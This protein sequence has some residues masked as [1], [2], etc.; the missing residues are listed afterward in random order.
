MAGD[1]EFTRSE[2]QYQLFELA[3]AGKKPG[4]LTNDDFDKEKSERMAALQ[5]ARENYLAAG[6]YLGVSFVDATLAD[7]YT[8]NR[9]DYCDKLCSAL[10]YYYKGKRNPKRKVINSGMIG[11]VLGSYEGELRSKLKESQC[12]CE[13]Q[14]KGTSKR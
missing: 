11:L 12:D 9:K 14:A 8:T 13:G 1:L 5:R 7:E 6:D 3:L 10:N 2:Y 4:D